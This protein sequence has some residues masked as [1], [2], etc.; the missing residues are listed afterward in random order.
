MSTTTH[1]RIFHETVV[2]SDN[3]L[4]QT[5]FFTSHNKSPPTQVT[6]LKADSCCPVQRRIIILLIDALALMKSK[7]NKR[8]LNILWNNWAC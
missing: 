5:L 3:F 2:H 8:L 1:L 7:N 4:Q 6:T